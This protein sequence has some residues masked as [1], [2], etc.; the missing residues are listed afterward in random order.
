MT[1]P[2][3]DTAAPISEEAVEAAAKVLAKMDGDAWD[4]AL[5]DY[6]LDRARF[7]LT[8]AAPFMLAEGEPTRV[9]VEYESP[10]TP[11]APHDDGWATLLYRIVCDEGWRESIR[12]LEEN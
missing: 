4:P 5:W 9:S 7:A 10:A 11:E 8:A 1:D 3:P 2:S 6:W 12:Y